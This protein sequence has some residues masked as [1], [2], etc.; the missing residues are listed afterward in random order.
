MKKPFL[1]ILLSLSESDRYGSAIQEDVR[2]LSE[3]RVRLWPA[4]LYGSLEKLM[5]LGWIR[6]LATHEQPPGGGGRG[7]ERFYQITRKGRR[8][9]AHEVEA[10]ESLAGIAR[11]RMNDAGA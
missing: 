3:G 6:E 10:M 4:T 7:R 2:D 9:L 1:Y 5:E 11:A 8:A